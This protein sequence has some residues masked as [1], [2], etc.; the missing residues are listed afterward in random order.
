MLYYHRFKLT[1]HITLIGTLI[2]C[3]YVHTYHHLGSK[4]VT[5]HIHRKIVVNAAIVHRLAIHIYRLE[6]ERKTHGCP[7]G[8]T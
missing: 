7:Y 8:I 5:H 6:H 4:Y 1:E 2:T 3:R